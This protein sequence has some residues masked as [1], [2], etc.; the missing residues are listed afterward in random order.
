MLNLGSKGLMAMII[1]MNEGNG[2]NKMLQTLLQAVKK[3]QKAN[4]WNQ[5]V[6]GLFCDYRKTYQE[7]WS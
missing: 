3:W 1:W 7:V 5:D 2:K 6:M 4:G